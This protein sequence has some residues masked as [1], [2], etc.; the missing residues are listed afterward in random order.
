MLTSLSA[1][2]QLLAAVLLFLEWRF[3]FLLVGAYA[4]RP[5][6]M[7]PVSGMPRVGSAAST[8]GE[9]A[10]LVWRWDAA[11]R[12]VVFR[13]KLTPVRGEWGHV[14][15]VLHLPVD[16]PAVLRWHPFPLLLVP[17]LLVFCAYATGV[18][19][20]V[21][22]QP[23]AMVL[24]AAAPL[25]GTLFGWMQV[26]NGTALLRRRGMVELREIAGRLAAT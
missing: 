11:R 15:G 25:L 18:F 19:V 4:R 9:T 13:R 3:H 16:G 23:E 26:S 21:Q 14:S 5:A 17:L 7:T 24:I 8:G 2:L 12:E 10:S 6:F 22:G 20:W 1:A